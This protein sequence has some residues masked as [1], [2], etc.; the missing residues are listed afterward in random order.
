MLV[1]AKKTM[2]FIQMGK[3][4]ESLGFCSNNKFMIIINDEKEMFP[5]RAEYFYVRNNLTRLERFKE[6]IES[7]TYLINEK[8]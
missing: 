5:Y 1:R 7:K 3:T 4:Y 8:I 2:N 6:M